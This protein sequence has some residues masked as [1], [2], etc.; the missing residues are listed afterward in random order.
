MTLFYGQAKNRLMSMIH[1]YCIH[2]K[3][4]KESWVARQLMESCD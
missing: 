3:R 2:A 4:F 1:W